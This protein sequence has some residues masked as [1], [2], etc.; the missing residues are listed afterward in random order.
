MPVGLSRHSEI[1]SHG[2]LRFFRGS[3]RSIMVKI[4]SQPSFQVQFKCGSRK[5]QQFPLSYGTLTILELL[6]DSVP[7]RKLD[8]L[9]RGRQALSLRRQARPRGECAF[10][11]PESRSH[12]VQ[13]L[14]LGA[15]TT[16]GLAKTREW[17]EE[18]TKLLIELAQ[19]KER[20]PAMARELGRHIASVRR[21]ALELGLLLPQGRSERQ[22]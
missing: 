12:L 18:E 4:R 22:L 5:P 7:A 20:V 8:L 16:M 1:S 10:I 21:R 13:H 2:S 17:T 11:A 6:I 19:R 3:L 14:I 15:N 9:C